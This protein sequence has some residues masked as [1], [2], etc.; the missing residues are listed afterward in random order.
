MPGWRPSQ[1]KGPWPGSPSCGAWKRE[2]SEETSEPLPGPKGAPGEQERDFG[3]GIEGQDTGNGFKLEKGK[4]GWDMEM[5]LF[6]V[7]VVRPWH[8]V[9]REAVATPGSL[10]AGQGL[11]QP[12]LWKVSLPMAR[13]WN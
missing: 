6:P 8:R 4:F 11:E 9:P 2:G 13:G 10:E 5:E 7:R 1:G 3:Q 12:A